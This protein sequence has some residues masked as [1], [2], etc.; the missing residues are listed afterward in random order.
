ML[1]LFVLKKDGCVYD[2]GYVALPARFDQGRAAFGTFAHGFA[3]VQ[4]P[5]RAAGA[6]GG[7]R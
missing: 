4:T 6:S 3:T 1:E 7:E 2:L 5:A